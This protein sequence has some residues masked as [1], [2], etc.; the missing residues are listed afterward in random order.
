MPRLIVAKSMMPLVFVVACGASPG[1]P[2]AAGSAPVVSLRNTEPAPEGSAA[3]VEPAETLQ[4]ADRAY[5]SQLGLARGGQ[6]D[7][8]RQIAV[9]EQ[10]VLLYTQF[11]ERA[12]GRPELQPAVRRSRERIDDAEQTIAFLRAS[13]RPAEPLP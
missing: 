8:E 10:S 9:L 2:R 1:P 12:E 5:D 6:F 4:Q 7:V 13:L 11:L 3:S